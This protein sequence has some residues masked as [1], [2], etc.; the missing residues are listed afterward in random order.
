MNRYGIA[1][2]NG[3]NHII[4]SDLDIN[5]L[6]EELT[7]NEWTGLRLESICKWQD[8]GKEPVSFLA[9]MVSIKNIEAICFIESED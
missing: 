7:K 5:Q 9:V 6:V 1:L 8:D 3:D 4:V 2:K